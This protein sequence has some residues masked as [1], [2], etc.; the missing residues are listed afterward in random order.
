MTPAA[1][2]GIPPELRRLRGLERAADLESLRRAQLSQ[3]KPLAIGVGLGVLL[4]GGAIVVP[5]LLAPAAHSSA[6]D[7]QRQSELARRELG[8][9]EPAVPLAVAR[10]DLAA[11]KSADAEK[12][13]SRVEK[14][15][16]E[17]AEQSSRSV[18]AARSADTSRG[19]PSSRLPQAFNADPNSM[20]LSLPNYEKIVSENETLLKSVIASAQSAA[21]AGGTTL[22]VSTVLGISR[23]IEAFGLVAEARAMR[24]KLTALQN[25]AASAALEWAIADGQVKHF[26]GIDVAPTETQLRSDIDEIAAAKSAASTEVSTLTE[27]ITANEAELVQLREQIAAERSA[28]NAAEAAGFTAGD[29][30]A[31][32]AHKARLLEISGRLAALQDREMA[33]ASGD[34]KGATVA[35]D[36][37]LDGA[38]EGG[39]EVLGLD[40]LKRRLSLATDQ[41][42]R[43]SRAEE[44]LNK[45]LADATAFGKFASDEAARYEA[46][47]KELEKQINGLIEQMGGLNKD[48]IAKEDEALASARGA[49]SA[50]STAKGAARGFVGEARTVRGDADKEG[51][52]ER[53]K[54]IVNDSA[55]ER[56]PEI[57]EAQARA[58][59]GMIHAERALAVESYKAG[60]EQLTKAIKGASYD[61]KALQEVIDTARNEANSA[62]AEAIGLQEKIASADRAAWAPQGGLAAM[63]YSTSKLDP[64]KAGQYL[65]MA[66]KALNAALK[67]ELWP[68]IRPE[69]RA[70]RPLLPAASGGSGGGTG[71]DSGGST[72]DDS[73]GGGG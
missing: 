20:R 7:A 51:K 52:N 68:H 42:A 54:T 37:L 64:S 32:R 33:L 40:E 70:L 49:V 21:T 16:Q 69:V 26:K 71:D 28:M 35:D 9:Y 58:M 13:V 34:L 12:L 53:L 6:T 46:R 65:D 38:I 61:P 44:S 50:F 5:P 43:L 57:F 66:A 18:Q 59:L 56:I 30:A 67:N 39:E 63:A 62:Y 2:D 36:D 22:G 19:V 27:R 15:L 41:L 14:Q 31:F 10:Q 47:Q 4:I 25:S 60:L 45:K 29:D 23:E 55:I 11:L 3:S 73:S 8:G 1:G 17:Y 24:K 48:A 72:G